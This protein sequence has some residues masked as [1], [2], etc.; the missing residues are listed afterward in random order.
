MIERALSFVALLAS[1]TLT[2]KFE[3]PAVVG[4]PLITPV[5]ALRERPAGKEPVRTL[6]ARGGTPSE[7]VRVAEYEAPTVPS[8]REAVVIVGT[9]ASPVANSEKDV[10]LPQTLLLTV[11]TGPEVLFTQA[12]VS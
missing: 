11:S 10:T 5:E 1:V 3:V 12:P 9:V 2:V 6:Q 7:A 4:V 8:G